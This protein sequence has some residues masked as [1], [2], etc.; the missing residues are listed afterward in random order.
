MR[1]V[2][3]HMFT[4]SVFSSGLYLVMPSLFPA[5]TDPDKKARKLLSMGDLQD[6]KM[7]VQH[8]IDPKLVGGDWNMTFIFPYIKHSNTNWLSYFSE[9]LKPP[10]S[11]DWRHVSTIFWAIYCWDI[12]LYRPYI[13]RMYGRYLQFR[14]LKWPLVLEGSIQ[15]CNGISRNFRKPSRFLFVKWGF[16]MS[17]VSLKNTMVIHDWVVIW[18]SLDGGSDPHRW[19]N[20]SATLSHLPSGNLT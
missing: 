14:S 4:G 1:L 19:L 8:H 20:C 10:T 17:R 18:E 6:P 13:S 5:L 3:L 9:G 12:P 16:L 15:G 11:K 7:E 2:S